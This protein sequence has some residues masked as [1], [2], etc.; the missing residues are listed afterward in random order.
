MFDYQ[1]LKGRI[2]EKYGSQSAF[3]NV[4][5]LTKQSVSLKLNNGI[6]F[7]QSE[8]LH[9]CELLDIENDQISEYFFRIKV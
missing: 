1:K 9:W 6:G 5:G 7:S 4:I 3:A 2:V 8:V